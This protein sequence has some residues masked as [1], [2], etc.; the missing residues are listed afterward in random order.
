M[1][2]NKEDQSKAERSKRYTR[3]QELPAASRYN[4]AE[5]LRTGSRYAEEDAEARAAVERLNMS[6]LQRLKS[7][8]FITI[9]GLIAMVL[10]LGGYL[11]GAIYFSD[12]YYPGTAVYGINCGARKLDWARTAVE[13]KI[14]SWTLTL[15][16]RGNRKELITAPDIDMHYDDQGALERRM[17]SQLNW[18][19]PVMMLVRRGVNTPIEAVYDRDRISPAIQALACFDPDNVTAP[20]DAFIEETEDGYRVTPE[21]MGTTLKA[22]RVSAL[23]EQA[24]EEGDTVI[25]LELKECYEYPEIYS[26]DPELNRIVKAKNSLLG[27][28]I[29]YDYDDR[30]E[31]VDTPVIMTFI[32]EDGNGGYQID[33]DRVSYYVNAMAD[34]YD[35]MGGTR[36][37]STTIG[38]VETLYGGDYGWAMDREATARELLAAIQEKRTAIMQ[39]VYMYKGMCRAANDIGDTYVE[40]CIARQQMW[41]YKDG[42]LIVDTPVV[43]GNV[44]A[45]NETPSGGVWAIDA[46]VEDYTLVG[47]GYSSP[48]DYWMPFNGNIGIHDM[49]SRYYF[50]STIY[51]T[52]GSHGCVNTPLEAVSQ[53]Y[54]AVEIGTPVVVYEGSR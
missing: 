19:W 22:E 40:I 18:L 37:F 39:P 6:F 43:T 10:A 30:K 9:A 28:G 42:E 8:D 21:V 45:G 47:E 33:P 11:A 24:V 51:L 4:D 12:H 16:E 1:Q 5:T 50:G 2:N 17:K 7:G 35:T 49:Q 52:H 41:C 25:N 34:T 31:V 53:I 26:D 44:S 23:V 38:T 13:E 32:T 46:K 3:E 14:G 15:E 36:T 20:C 29:T 48:V 54:E 27:A